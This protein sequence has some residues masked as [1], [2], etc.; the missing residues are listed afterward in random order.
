MNNKGLKGDIIMSEKDKIVKFKKEIDFEDFLD[1]CI[2]C[3][4]KKISNEDFFKWLDDNLYVKTYLPLKTKCA[5]IS[6]ILLDDFFVGTNNISTVISQIEL[7]KFYRILLSYT[8]IN[9]LNRE[10][11]QTMENYDIVMLCL[12]NVLYDIIGRDY[13][14]TIEM[15]NNSIRNL[16]L[17]NILEVLSTK[18]EKKATGDLKKIFKIFEENQETIDKLLKILDLNNNKITDQVIDGITKE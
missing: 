1:I 4:N 11:L 12:G 7:K 3:V 18:D 10:D 2:K 16:N 5:I 9:V 8:N 14:R 17:Q 15:L 13:D 6:Y